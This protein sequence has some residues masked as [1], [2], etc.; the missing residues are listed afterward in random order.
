MKKASAN[1]SQAAPEREATEAKNKDALEQSAKRVAALYKSMREFEAL[2]E[3]KAGFELTKAAD[4][5]AALEQ[6]LVEARE[7][8]KTAGE[9]FKTFQEKYAPEYKR[10]R[11]YKVL[12]I[13]DGRTTPEEVREED[14]ERK[15]RQRAGESVRD[16]SDVTDKSAEGE[17]APAKPL[18]INETVA[19]LR[20]RA[21]G[22]GYQL[23]RRGDQ[24]LLIGEHGLVIGIGLDDVARQL[25]VY[26]GKVS[27]PVA[28]GNAEETAEES[29][30]RR[31]ADNAALGQ[32][33]EAVKALRSRAESL[34]YTLHRRGTRL[35][36]KSKDGGG[37][38]SETDNLDDAI[39]VVTFRLDSEEGKIATE[40]RSPCGRLLG[41]NAEAVK[42]YEAKHGKAPAGNDAKETAEES[43]DRRKGENAAQ[44][45]IDEPSDA[46]GDVPNIA[47]VIKAY[48]IKPLQERQTALNN[49]AGLWGVEPAEAPPVTAVFDPLA[50]DRLNHHIN[51]L[52]SLC[53][54]DGLS[55]R[56]LRAAMKKRIGLMRKLLATPRRKEGDET[57]ERDRK[58]NDKVIAAETAALRARGKERVAASNAKAKEH[59]AALRERAK[60]LGYG[61]NRRGG[62][63]CLTGGDST[64]DW[65]TGLAGGNI[66][67][68]IKRVSEQLDC[69][70]GSR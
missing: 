42:A 68:A 27:T 5:R 50:V 31:K 67:E 28:A 57:V 44:A 70:A 45:D 41:T 64:D 56:E 29:A 18:S 46:F 6:A 34:G 19:H 59:I 10:T 8:C 32:G 63:L 54:E 66:A 11:L 23:R 25:D 7:L 33:E 14:R 61:L 17:E 21:K 37:S 39:A 53:Q 22:L 40:V 69:L 35:N 58:L 2:A 43:A 4:K 24:I 9:S 16:K 12:A 1:K 49:I 20:A 38:Y 26:E 65:A 15:R 3:E 62:R 55:A 60:G 30:D 51:A 52:W 36:L 48:I 13:A 47:A